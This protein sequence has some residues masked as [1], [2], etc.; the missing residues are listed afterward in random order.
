MFINQSK[1]NH[2]Y[3]LVW[4][5]WT[6]CLGKSAENISTDTYYAEWEHRLKNVEYGLAQMGDYNYEKFDQLVRTL[7]GMPCYEWVLIE[8]DNTSFNTSVVQP[9]KLSTL[10]DEPA[11]KK[12]KN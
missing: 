10:E 5:F 9:T 2:G 3:S 6:V 11:K 12:F 8:A 4:N 7:R 1:V